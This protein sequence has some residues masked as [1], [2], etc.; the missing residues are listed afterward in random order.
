MWQEYDP[1]DMNLFIKIEAKIRTFYY[2]Y[3]IPFR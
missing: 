3:D 2:M 1:I